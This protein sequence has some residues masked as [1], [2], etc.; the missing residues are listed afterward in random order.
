MNKLSQTVTGGQVFKLMPSLMN[1]VNPVAFEKYLVPE[2]FYDV[3]Y[4]I[5]QSKKHLLLRPAIN[6]AKAGKIKFFN[7]SDPIDPRIKSVEIPNYIPVFIFK[8]KSGE[9]V[10]YVNVSA[11]AGYRR[12]SAGEAIGISLD[13]NSVHYYL[14]I[15][16][17]AKILAD[18]D[19]DITNNT[20]FVTLCAEM[21]SKLICLCI[22]S[23]YPIGADTRK[24]II[25]NFLTI[26]FF[27]Q[28]HAGYTLEQA[29]PLA[30]KA[31]TVDPLIIKSDS[32]TYANGN[33]KMRSFQEFCD[34]LESEFTF[35]KKGS[36]SLRSIT[37]T[38]ITKYGQPSILFPEH[39]QSFLIMIE[40][41]DL[42]SRIYKDKYIKSQFRPTDISTINQILLVASGE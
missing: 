28:F 29:L 42:M 8:D 24:F 37:T 16:A 34:V 4:K 18:N 35:I 26:L 20:K 39:F 3:Y 12:N 40:S 36:I 1:V 23:V 41:V 2:S 15:G 10:A 9:S 33:L 22:D 19:K 14:T 31:R 21:Y 27:L 11:K 17:A 13:E 5:L 6:Y 38:A 25:L 32:S 7:A 30:L